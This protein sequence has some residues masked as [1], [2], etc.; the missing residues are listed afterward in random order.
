MFRALSNPHRL[1][2]FERLCSCC[3]PGT[4][5]DVQTIGV[6]ELGSTLD[7]APSTLSHHLKTL[8]DAGLVVTERRGK[9]VECHVQPAVLEALSAFF[10][11]PLAAVEPY[12]TCSPGEPH[13]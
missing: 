13:V 11:R 10:S 8:R 7:I 2:I 12:S 1:A 4:R 6:G 3:A 5:C 9:R